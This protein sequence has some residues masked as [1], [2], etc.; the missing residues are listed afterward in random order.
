M[1]IASDV[2]GNIYIAD[3]INHVIKKVSSGTTTTVAGISGVR[4]FY[5]DGGQATS[6]KLSDPAG[7]D[8]DSDGNI[9]IAD[10][11]NSVIRK[12]DTSGTITTIAGTG[13]VRGYWGDGT[14]AIVEVQRL[15]EFL[16]V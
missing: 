2:N 11:G 14:A 16:A 1:D 4:G 7:I 5:G 13:G 12:V 6:A 8:V 3:F 15:M 10:F 9:Y